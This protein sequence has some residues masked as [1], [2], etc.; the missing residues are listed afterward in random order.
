MLLASLLVA[1]VAH[2]AFT[3]ILG[4]LGEFKIIWF[5]KQVAAV[6]PNAILAL[7]FSYVLIK[8]K[9]ID[10]EETPYVKMFKF[11]GYFML[12]QILVNISIL[13][14]MKIIG[15]DIDFVPLLGFSSAMLS[16]LIFSWLIQK[17]L[18]VEVGVAGSIFIAF[19]TVVSLLICIIFNI[20]WFWR[21]SAMGFA[22]AL[23]IFKN[24]TSQSNQSVTRK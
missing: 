5:V 4:L 15:K 21:F 2:M 24:L 6:V 10:S 20:S 11:S 18:K 7:V 23:I 12:S 1:S 8:F 19:I 22:G 9:V 17:V 13:E 3:P 14:S 16:G